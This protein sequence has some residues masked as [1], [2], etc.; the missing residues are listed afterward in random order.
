[1]VMVILAMVMVLLAVTIVPEV[2]R[3]AD[4]LRQC[5]HQGFQT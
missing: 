3:L 1:M 5:Q 2:L 4:W